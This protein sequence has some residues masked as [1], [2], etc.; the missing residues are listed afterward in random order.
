MVLGFLLSGTLLFSQTPQCITIVGD[1]NNPKYTEILMDSRA[2]TWS[3]NRQLEIVSSAWTCNA[4][5]NPTCNFRGILKYNVS[6]IP[7]NATITSA[8]LYLYAK[9]DALN[10]NPGNP[11]FGQGNTSLLQRVTGSWTTNNFGWD[12][13]P[14]ATTANQ[15]VLPQ[16]SSTVQN[17]EVNVTDFVQQW[18]TTPS[19]NN[20][21]LLR[22]QTETYYNSMIFNGGTAPDALKPKLEICYTVPTSLCESIAITPGNG[23]ITISGLTS[24]IAQVQVSNSAW[25]TVFSQ[26]YTNA[27]GTI[28]IPSLPAGPYFVKVSLYNANWSGICTK[29]QYNVT[30]TGGSQVPSLSVEDISVNE[31]G[32]T[33][34]PKICLSA[35]ATQQVTV[36]YTTV[37]GSA[38]AGSDYVAKSGTAIF[39]VGVTC[40]EIP[41]SI[42][43]DQ[44]PE[45]TETFT[46]SISQPVNATILKANGTISIIDND[47]PNSP[48]STL[49]FAAVP[50]GIEFRNLVAPIALVQVSN[51][52][53]A[54]VYSEVLYNVNGTV[55]VPSLPAGQYFCRVS[56]FNSSWQ[57]ICEKTDFVNVT[58]G[59]LPVLYVQ[60]VTVNENAGTATVQ[61]CF[62]GASN[63]PVSFNFA[64]SNGSAL[65]TLDYTATN[66]TRTIPVGQNCATF[67]V[68]ILDDNIP[69]G[70]ETFTVNISAPVNATIGDGSAVI[71]I[72]DNDQCPAGAICVRNTCPSSTVNLNTAYSIPNLPA[73][74]VVSWHSGTP[75]TNNN[76]LTTVQVEAAGAGVYY[77]ALNITAANCYSSTTMVI[78][79]IYPCQSGLE[80]RNTVK[81]AMT[82]AELS[83]ANITA[84]PN[85][86]SNGVLVNVES[87][88]DEKAEVSLLD[89]YGRLITSRSVNLRVGKNQVMFDGLA[90]YAAGAYMVRIQ[91][92]T[93]TD[94]IKLV[95]QAK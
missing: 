59:T 68:S 49:T 8:K 52:S 76:K 24:P 78:V 23:N 27:P 2:P 94:V 26:V 36:N 66:G 56:I 67:T 60:D 5:G 33:V 48:C 19:L 61:V 28:T 85:P 91:R 71:T 30:V 12:N 93:S 83:R 21:M 50:G 69:E 51:S 18:V 79:S 22:L 1:I 57:T 62:N 86:F 87:V 34:N 15:K 38:T 82:A 58:G 92:S 10:G 7:T 81:A 43:E 45:V 41:I 89:V 9:T 88:K 31:N 64:T 40:V 63:Q 35:P 74:T 14:P 44:S 3:D 84:T 32:G 90:K 42:T 75:A 20:G 16:S 80:V 53:W 70:T 39:P 47:Q 73:G 11:M 72:T 6:E 29:E 77:A 37:N 13:Q 95:K 17:Y 65:S 25:A 4:T 46:L 55:A 54:N